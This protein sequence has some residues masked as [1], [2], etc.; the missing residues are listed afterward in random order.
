MAE[1]RATDLVGKI[2]ELKKE[3]KGI[4]AGKLDRDA[5][6]QE[7]VVFTI[8]INN[9]D[10]TATDGVVDLGVIGGGGSGSYDDTELRQE[11]ND[12]KEN[13]PKNT[14]DLEND[15]DFITAASVEGMLENK[16]NQDEVDELAQSINNK[17]DAETGKGLSTN[18]FTTEEKTK[19]SN[20][21]NYNDTEIKTALANKVDKETGKGLS[22]ND[23]TAEYKNTLDNISLTYLTQKDA[24]DNYATIKFVNE[25]V[26]VLSSTITS[27][28]DEVDALDES[29]SGKVDKVE[30]KGLST[31]DFTDEYKNDLDNMSDIYLTKDEASSTYVTFSIFNSEFND[32]AQNISSKADSSE[33]SSLSNKVNSLESE[34]SAL[35]IKVGSL[36]SEV[37]VLGSDTQSLNS[38]VSLLR[39]DISSLDI[40]MDSLESEVVALNTVGSRVTSLESEVSALEQTCQE[41]INNINTNLSGI[42]DLLDEINGDITTLLNEIIGEEAEK[43][44][45]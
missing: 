28:S 19:L 4:K 24:S 36:N 18:D 1:L 2:S 27:L 33:V 26:G 3:I 34:V 20:L 11:I 7:G 17:V 37:T 43:W 13:I 44:E 42:E 16:A 22:T 23:F 6:K 39:N 38:E 30:G 32:L 10:Y 41:N 12:I 9:K 35:D 21:E 40:S 14:S 25:E 45:I 29:V 8:S 5:L 31:N 15:S